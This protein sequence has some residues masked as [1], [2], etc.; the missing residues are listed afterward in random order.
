[1]ADKTE[2]MA[3]SREQTKI[4]VLAVERMLSKHYF[5]SIA[6]IRERLD[7]HYGIKADTRTVFSDLMAIDRLYPLEERRG[8]Y[9]GYRRMDVMGGC[10]GD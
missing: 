2:K 10:D 9:G 1:M 8:R 5:I 6:K 4:R 3:L 7:R